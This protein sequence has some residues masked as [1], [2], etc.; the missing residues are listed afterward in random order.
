MKRNFLCS[1]IIGILLI[2]CITIS[3]NANSSQTKAQTA[4]TN[5]AQNI[6]S[7]C[8]NNNVVGMSLAVFKQGRIIYTQSY[9]YADRENRI[10]A[11]SKTKYRSASISKP[12][13]AIGAM[14][15]A[16]QGML[17]LDAPI[18]EIIGVNLDN[19]AKFPNT[20]RNLMTH[21]STI[22]D[23][24]A[25]LKACETLPFPS[26]NGLKSFGSIFTANT[27]GT[28][29][30]YSNFGAGLVAAV[31]ESSTKMRFY[32]YM[33]ENIFD[34]LGMDAAYIRTHIN[35]TDD[36]AKIYQGG[37]F[38][39]N[40]KTWGRTERIYD[41]VPL[42]QQYLIGQCELI[43]SAPDLAKIGIMLA[44]DGSIDDTQILSAESVKE[45]SRPYIAADNQFY[46]IGLR[47]NKNIV[48]GRAIAGHPGQALGMVGGLY[49]D[50]SDKTGVAILTNGCSIAMQ[51]NGVYRINN[52][53]VRAVYENFDKQASPTSK[54]IQEEYK[55]IVNA[56]YN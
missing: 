39:Y 47:I 15:L 33:D 1:L 38:A 35:D 32:D 42:G 56:L 6:N 43:I 50:R 51:D 44:G 40:P 45:M 46:G 5:F 25:Y 3:A 37:I 41:N 14:I 52:E 23:T 2:P 54:K 53:I 10:P 9:G 22:G 18:S 21:T 31:I 17:D 29:Y 30:Q 55:I 7:I 34:K 11:T 36:I 28:R 16:E 49:F 48:D 24:G 8:K 19:N 4:S 20:T 26:L 27:P 13:T 12:V